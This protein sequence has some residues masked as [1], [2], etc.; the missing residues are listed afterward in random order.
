CIQVA[1]NF[2]E[3]ESILIKKAEDAKN[4]YASQIFKANHEYLQNSLN[5]DI[6]AIK[7]YFK[8]VAKN[9]EEFKHITSCINSSF[10]V[11]CDVK[12]LEKKELQ[13]LL[14]QT[15]NFDYY[16]DYKLGLTSIEN[17]LTGV[18]N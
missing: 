3:V 13:V 2:D 10:N 11:K 9:N 6:T 4:D 7:Y 5:S 18:D 14:N 12:L 8:F 16:D 15:I 1:K 17:Q